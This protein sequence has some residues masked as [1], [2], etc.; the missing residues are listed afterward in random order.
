MGGFPEALASTDYLIDVGRGSGRLAK[1]LSSTLVEGHYLGIDICPRA[2]RH[3]GCGNIIMEAPR[4][5]WPSIKH[6]HCGTGR[7]GRIFSILFRADD[8]LS[9]VDTGYLEEARRVLEPGRGNFSFPPSNSRSLDRP[10]FAATLHNERNG[11]ES[12]LTD[13]IERSAMTVWANT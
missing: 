4:P 1:P 6:R 8:P 7:S 9:F 11:I 12:P 3:D 13:F 10:A 2:P 5:S